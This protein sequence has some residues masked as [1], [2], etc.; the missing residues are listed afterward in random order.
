[1]IKMVLLCGTLL[2]VACSPPDEQQRLEKMGM[3]PAGFVADI[4]KG[5]KLFE[6]NCATCHGING[7]G[8]NLGPPLVHKVYEPSHHSDLAFYYAIKKGTKAH[9]WDFGDMPSQ[10]QVSA[11]EAGH[12]VEYIRD[13][14]SRKD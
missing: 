9:H 14:Q 5:K 11:T 10:P 13:I 6:R 8:T 1:M 12:I 7:I 4:A 2:L 3:P